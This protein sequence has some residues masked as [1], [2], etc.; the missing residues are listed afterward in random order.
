MNYLSFVICHLSFRRAGKQAFPIYPPNCT[1]CASSPAC[2]FRRRL[3]F[4]K[5]LW[6]FNRLL[7]STRLPV[8]HSPAIRLQFVFLNRTN[9]R[10]GCN[11]LPTK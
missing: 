11:R 2:F 7:L 1:V 6:T 8:F 5:R 9:Q 4:C 3:Q 10:H